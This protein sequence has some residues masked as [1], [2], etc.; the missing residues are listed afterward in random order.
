[1]N[2]IESI[3]ESEYQTLNSDQRELLTNHLNSHIVKSEITNFAR[4]LS[5]RSNKVDEAMLNDPDVLNLRA[6]VRGVKGGVEEEMVRNHETLNLLNAK[7]KQANSSRVEM[8]DDMDFVQRLRDLKKKLNVSYKKMVSVIQAIEFQ[9]F[10]KM[11]QPTEL[12]PSFDRW[13]FRF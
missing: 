8:G 13:G 10:K 4:E 2:E 3:N 11:E 7:L 1:M 5:N 12:R 6:L 9:V